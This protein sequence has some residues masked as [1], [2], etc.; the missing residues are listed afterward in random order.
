MPVEIVDRDDVR[1]YVHRPEN[2][3]SGALA[4]T[5]GAGSDAKAPLLVA[6]AEAL[7]TAGLTVLRFD[8]PFRR[9]RSAGPPFPAQAAA[10]RDGIRAGVDFLIRD[11]GGPVYLG[12]HSY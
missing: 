4:L 3:P 6:W 5:H 12:G 2:P 11:T 1:G 10:D 9:S 8:L 7:S